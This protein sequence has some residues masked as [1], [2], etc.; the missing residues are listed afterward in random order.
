MGIIEV[1]LYKSHFHYRENEADFLDYVI[2]WNWIDEES[3]SENED[4]LKEI[5]TPI[6]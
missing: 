2:S 3:P 1:L 4:I 5:R 6:K